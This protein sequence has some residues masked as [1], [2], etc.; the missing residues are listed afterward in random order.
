MTTTINEK[1]L[2]AT[3]TADAVLARLQDEGFSVEVTSRNGSPTN[4]GDITPW[5]IMS[6]SIEGVAIRV[7]ASVTHGK[8][9]VVIEERGTLRRRPRR[10]VEP[11]GGWDVK[12]IVVGVCDVLKKRE[13]RQLAGK[14]RR[15]RFAERDA[16]L[17]SL[18]SCCGNDKAIEVTYGPNGA[19]VVRVTIAGELIGLV[20]SVVTAARAELDRADDDRAFRSAEA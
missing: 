15:A 4:G 14:A 17:A 20:E 16:K 8:G 2:R 18:Q 9:T 19:W 11:Q 12:R 5:L 13:V 6:T 3:R 10:F 7:T 1:G